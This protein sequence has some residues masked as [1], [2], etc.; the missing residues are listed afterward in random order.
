LS[1]FSDC[2]HLRRSPSVVEEELE[3]EEL[4]GVLP[5]VSL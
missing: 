1:S 3:D 5:F 2:F 4:D